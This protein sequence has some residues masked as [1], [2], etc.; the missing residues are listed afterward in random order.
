MFLFPLLGLFCIAAIGQEILLPLDV[1][2]QIL[3]YRANNPPQK[4]KSLKA[5]DTLSLP[6]RDDFSTTEV[7]PDPNLWMDENVYINSNWADNLLSVGI[8]TFDII[9]PDGKVYADSSK[10]SFFADVLTSKPI[11]L[12]GDSIFL[13]FY[14]QAG[15]KGDMPD[16]KDTIM[17]EFYSPKTHKWNMVWYAP[18][19]ASSIKYYKDLQFHL[20]LIPITDNIYLQKGFQF[21]FRNRASLSGTSSNPGKISMTVDQ[22][23]I[24]YVYLD[25][26]RTA[27]YANEDISFYKPLASVLTTYTAMPFDQFKESYKYNGIKS[28]IEF[29]LRNNDTITHPPYRSVQITERNKQR[30]KVDSIG[31]YNIAPQHSEPYLIY[32]DKEF[33]I[34]TKSTKKV[35]YDIKCYID[36]IDKWRGNDTVRN[37]LIL[38]DYFAYDDGTSEFGYSCS[39]GNYLAYGFNTF[40]KDTLTGVQIYFNPT[41]KESSNNA[42]FQLVVWSDNNGKPGNRIFILADD[43]LKPKATNEFVPFW[44]DTAIVVSGKFY[45]GLKNLTS[46]HLNIGYDV[47]TNCQNALFYSYSGDWYTAG[48]Q[49]SETPVGSLMMRPIMRTK[50]PTNAVPIIESLS[51]VRVFPNPASEYIQLNKRSDLNAITKILFYNSLGQI[52]YSVEKPD[53]GSIDIRNIPS[54]LYLLKIFFQKG[55]PESIKLLKK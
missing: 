53:S 31:R 51:Q 11:N 9:G 25:S 14:F 44:F 5:A 47:N 28:Q 49:S 24:D 52:I 48:S 7:L 17:L 20:V 41:Y 27:K 42:N 46:Q 2:P 40:I 15:G 55:N 38:D 6:F 8:A 23:H 36:S 43:N 50:N 54:G 32:F 3:K 21:R 30:S 19:S 34:E 16:P 37:S 13:S 12:K 18:D 26:S 4:T 22:W 39:E 10:E 35:A 1:N 29:N 45:V 33:L